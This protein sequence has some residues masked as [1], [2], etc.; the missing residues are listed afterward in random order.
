M[1]G[2]LGAV[3]NYLHFSYEITSRKRGGGGYKNVDDLITFNINKTS[4]YTTL[5]LFHSYTPVKNVDLITR[6]REG[7]KKL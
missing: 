4:G 2:P 1:T 5:A 7:V 3:Q 6:G